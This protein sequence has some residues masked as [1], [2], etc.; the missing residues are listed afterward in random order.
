M[1]V[2][3]DRFLS[4]HLQNC[5]VAVTPDGVR[6]MMTLDHAELNEMLEELVA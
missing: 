4:H 6:W 1:S 5:L 3:Y 2:D